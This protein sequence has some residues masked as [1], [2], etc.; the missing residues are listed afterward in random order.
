MYIYICII[1]VYN[2]VYV[3]TYIF[4]C[5]IYVYVY[6]YGETKLIFWSTGKTA[7]KIGLVGRKNKNSII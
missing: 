5:I 2:Y 1:Y 4:T 3:C 7:N 6:L